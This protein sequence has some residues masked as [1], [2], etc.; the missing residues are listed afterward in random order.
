MAAKT[1]TKRQE[2]S[3]LLKAF[4][5]VSF[6]QSDSG[7]E[8]QTH[9]IVGNN[10]IVAFNG[11]LAMG[12]TIAEDLDACPHTDK[13][14]LALAQCGDSFAITQLAQ[15]CLLVRSGEFEAFVPCCERARLP[16]VKPDAPVAPVSDALKDALR[17]VAP[18]A[19]EKAAHVVM[20]AI[21]LHSGS[22]AATN[23]SVVLEAWHGHD[24]P[25]NLLIP[26]S[27]A[28]AVIKCGRKL[29]QFGLS[30]N[31][32]TFWFEDRSWIRTQLYREGYS[33]IRTVFDFD[34]P[35][36]TQLTP[37]FFK[38]FKKVA[39]FSEDGFVYCWKG[40]I[41][42][43][44]PHATSNA[45]GK[46]TLE[47]SGLTS[48]QQYRIADLKLLVDYMTNINDTHR[49]LTLFNNPE[50]KVRGAVWHLRITEPS[51]VGDDDIP[52]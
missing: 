40:T 48:D 1:K 19:N 16:E 9:S 44:H 13:M 50:F 34:G 18:L 14:R 20:A 46:L 41:G 5:F 29:T 4:K 42:S 43:H 28:L 32:V 17:I 31:T 27:A 15:N 23:N 45:G 8:M 39:P 25:N 36:Y 10:S 52:F 51:P 2:E 26:K 24:L 30:D 6:C 35:N 11:V 47:V 33:N 7:N 37:E 49:C 22:V 3:A 38:A 12:Q 21:Q